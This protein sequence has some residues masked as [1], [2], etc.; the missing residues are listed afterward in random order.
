MDKIKESFYRRRGCERWK[1]PAGSSKSNFLGCWK[2]SPGRAV[3]QLGGERRQT[4]TTHLPFKPLS[5]RLPTDWPGLRSPGTTLPSKVVEQLRGP[6]RSLRGHLVSATVIKLSS[7]PFK[8]RRQKGRSTIP[9]ADGFPLTCPE[10]DTSLNLGSEARGPPR[11]SPHTGQPAGRRRC[12][13]AQGPAT[14]PPLRT[15]SAATHVFSVSFIHGRQG[16]PSGHL[17][18]LRLCTTRGRKQNRPALGGRRAA[19]ASRPPRGLGLDPRPGPGRAPAGP[20]AH[21]PPAPA[22]A[23]RSPAGRGG[24]AAG[25]PA[26][27]GV[28]R[29]P[30]R[31]PLPLLPPVAPRSSAPGPPHSA[32]GSPG[33][34]GAAGG[35]G[36][37]GAQDRPPR[38]AGADHGGAAG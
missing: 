7:R 36:E 5:Q 26:P 13:R 35:C 18:A 10:E 14:R 25:V 17:T 8:R 19:A 20:G 29:A 12:S 4:F 9:R 27:Q 32:A 21:S 22:A 38:A 34:G 28:P 2:T 33:R 1:G 6:Q 31:S 23:A 15:G 37:G 24:R 16:G 30:A 3:L 11:P